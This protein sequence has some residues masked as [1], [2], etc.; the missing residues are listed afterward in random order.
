MNVPLDGEIS[1]RFSWLYRALASQLYIITCF[2]MVPILWLLQSELL[3]GGRG[4][5]PSGAMAPVW[6]ESRAASGQEAL[7]HWGSFGAESW[8]GSRGCSR[9]E[10]RLWPCPVCACVCSGP[11]CSITSCEAPSDPVAGGFTSSARPW[12]WAR[13]VQVTCL[14]FRSIRSYFEAYRRSADVNANVLLRKTWDKNFCC[15]LYFILLLEGKIHL[16]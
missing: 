1:S 13:I 4:H 5:R 10:R 7:E 8:T 15:N 9:Q 12:L 16:G 2:F 11:R 3:D 6:L 14:C